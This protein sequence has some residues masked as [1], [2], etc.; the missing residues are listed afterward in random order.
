M[1]GL[2]PEGTAV[3]SSPGVGG[4]EGREA[5]LQMTKEQFATFIETAKA[6][7]NLLMG[8]LKAVAP[9]IY[10]AMIGE[11]DAYMAAGLDNLKFDSTVA[12]MGIAHVDGV[13]K[14]LQANGWVV[15]P[16]ACPVRG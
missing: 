9:E 4:D 5:D 16:A 2:V 10:G 7:E 8:N 14:N 15:V 11:R 13:E 3:A 12:V 1:Q 6:K